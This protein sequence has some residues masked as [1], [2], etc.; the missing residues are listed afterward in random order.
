[1]KEGIRKDGDFCWINMLT[2][3]PAKA[4]EFYAELLG[5]TFFP[6][7]DIGYGIRVGGH[8]V[9]GM[10]DVEAPNTPPG[11]RAHIGVM[12][13][14]A[15]ADA[16]AEKVKSLGGKAQP[17]FDIFDAGRMAVCNDPNGANF[18]PW[19]PKSLKGFDVNTNVHGAP[20][21][22]ETLTTDVPRAK[23]FYMDLFGWQAESMPMPQGEYITFKLG[24]DYVAG[25][26][27]I[28][29][30]MG[31]MRPHWGTYFT[32]DKVDE[33]EKLARKLGAEICM[34]LMDVP[35]V[36]RMCGIMSPQGVMFYAIT[37]ASM[38]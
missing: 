29:P 33:T 35:G 22:F 13:K 3:Q 4:R 7:G 27:G 32:V 30:E 36:G 21:W 19:Q 14:V 8:D 15:N 9:G 38:A 2:P 28:T 37:Y 17:A 16:T 1:M 10:F 31:E 18:D 34:P 26:M 12:V 25:M 23:K 24:D 11:T 20:S 6:M 5:W